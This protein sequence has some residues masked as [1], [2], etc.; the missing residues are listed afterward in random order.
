VLAGDHTGLLEDL[1]TA[2]RVDA[3]NAAFPRLSIRLL[4]HPMPLFHP[5]RLQADITA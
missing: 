4:I 2:H 5:R 3:E 1:H